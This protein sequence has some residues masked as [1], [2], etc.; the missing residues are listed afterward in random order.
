MAS[1]VAKLADD[2]PARVEFGEGVFVSVRRRRLLIGA[3]GE[4][5]GETHAFRRRHLPP[6]A[7]RRR[8]HLSHLRLDVARRRCGGAGI[9]Q[10]FPRVPEFFLQLDDAF[11]QVNLLLRRRLA[12]LAT[13]RAVRPRVLRLRETPR[14]HLPTPGRRGGRRLLRGGRRL[15]RRRR[16]RLRQSTS[17][18][19]VRRQFFR[20]RSPFQLPRQ[21]VPQ[22]H[23][24]RAHLHHL[25]AH[26]R[27]LAPRLLHRRVRGGG[28]G[29]V[30]LGASRRRLRGALRQF[31]RVVADARVRRRS[32]ARLARRL[33]RR[34]G[35]LA[36]GFFGRARRRVPPRASRSRLGRVGAR[37]GGR[38]SRRVCPSAAAGLGAFDRSTLAS[39]SARYA[40]VSACA[41]SA[42]A[43]T[44]SAWRRIASRSDSARALARTRWCICELHASS[45]F[46]RRAS[47]TGIAS[48]THLSA[49][50][51]LWRRSL[52]L[53]CVVSLPAPNA[54]ARWPCAAWRRF[55]RCSLWRRRCA[56]AGPLAA[57]TRS[58]S[59]ARDRGFEIPPR[60][61]RRRAN[62]GRPETPPAKGASSGGWRYRRHQ[63]VVV[64]ERRA[65]RGAHGGA[66][67]APAHRTIGAIAGRE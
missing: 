29:F 27:R 65:A 4:L 46:L 42:S 61:S 22:R 38:V 14:F 64:A 67:Q 60:R 30:F 53:M 25:R 62:A 49:C 20:R 6:Q 34:R 15:L 32:N 54:L 35:R 43:R 31:P 45:Q 16:A 5:R 33:L 52:V 44:V 50:A 13:L 55:A 26:L 11:L 36:G 2:V 18:R 8:L 10:T 19:R 1:G 63:A 56:N 51:P 28:G 3:G 12:N 57:L 21:A 17:L 48:A 59:D 58:T 41:A 47:P 39:I 23:H 40:S 9:L 24:L 37:A 7:S 66:R